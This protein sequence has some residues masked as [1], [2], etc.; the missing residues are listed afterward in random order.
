MFFPRRRINSHQLVPFVLPA[1][2]PAF[3]FCQNRHHAKNL[4]EISNSKIRIKN[5]N[6][7]PKPAKTFST[8]TRGT[9]L[10]CVLYPLTISITF[11]ACCLSESPLFSFSFFCIV[12]PGDRGS[13]LGLS[14]IILASLTRSLSRVS[15]SPSFR[16]LSIFYSNF[17]ISPHAI[18][19]VAV[20]M[21]NATKI[22]Q[23]CW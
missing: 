18:A 17:R 20:L 14:S 6:Q 3:S 23:E 4:P 8:M 11:F 12:M 22:L 15:L 1:S 2:Q 10:L 19:I 9:A 7:N 21:I 16:S 13:G 5:R